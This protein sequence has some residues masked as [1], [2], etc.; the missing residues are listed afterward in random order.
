[1]SRLSSYLPYTSCLM[2]Y[3]LPYYGRFSILHASCKCRVNVNILF[4]EMIRVSTF[5]QTWIPFYAINPLRN[6]TNWAFDVK[7]RRRCGEMGKQIGC[8]QTGCGNYTE[9]FFPLCNLYLV[10]FLSLHGLLPLRALI[11][12]HHSNL[13]VVF[14]GLTLLWLRVIAIG[15]LSQKHPLW[16]AIWQQW[17]RFRKAGVPSRMI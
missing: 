2:C 13:L 7:T 8:W 15:H 5:L 12:D 11:D 16:L 4:H 17:G 9:R 3:V 6:L 1:M 14:P 10:W